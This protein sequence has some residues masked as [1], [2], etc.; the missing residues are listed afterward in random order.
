MAIF[1]LRARHGAAYNPGSAT[2]LVFSD[3]PAGHWASAWIERFA[4]F[5]YTTGCSSQPAAFCPSDLVTR[6]QMA[7]FLQRVFNLIGPP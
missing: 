7:I 1:L 2:G 5:G 6:A 3:V 4:A